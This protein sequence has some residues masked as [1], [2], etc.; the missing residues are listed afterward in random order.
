MRRAYRMLLH[1]YPREHQ[2]Q[3]SEEMFA[4]FTRVA[5]ERRAQGRIAYLRFV[6]N[7]CIGLLSGAC[8]EWPKRTSLAPALG[9]VAVAAV[10]HAAFYAAAWKC[11]RAIGAIV[12]RTVIPPA[13]PRAPGLALAMLSVTVLLCLLPVFVL[14]SMR[15]TPRRR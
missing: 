14:L 4:V 10:L 5:Q 13:D 1:L 12:N 11:L 6:I 7:E 9:G 3:F 2:L 8:S 15:L